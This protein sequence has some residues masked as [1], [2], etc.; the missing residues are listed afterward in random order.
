MSTHVEILRIPV[1]NTVEE[2]TVTAQSAAVPAED[3][4]IFDSFTSEQVQGLVHQVFFPSSGKLRRQI[5]F[6]A[7]DDNVDVGGICTLVAECL[8]ER[9]G[10]TVAV[11]DAHAC[12]RDMSVNPTRRRPSER[13]GFTGIRGMSNQVSGNLWSVSGPVFW[14]TDAHAGSPA[15]VPRTIGGVT[16]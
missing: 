8:S 4:P 14:G 13:V 6:S 2:K 1:S 10:E 7:V 15:W 3:Q 9:V 5:I 16:D 11:V 12:S